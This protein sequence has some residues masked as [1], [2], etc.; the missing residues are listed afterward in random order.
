MMNNTNSACSDDWKSRIHIGLYWTKTKPTQ[1][2]YY[3]CSIRPDKED[4][5]EIV[6]VENIIDEKGIQ[7]TI[8]IDEYSNCDINDYTD[9]N[10]WYGPI[11]PPMS[12]DPA[13]ILKALPGAYLPGMQRGLAYP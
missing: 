10:W 8:G 13:Y 1:P 2:G 12:N 5:C 7:K 9:N 11:K 6:K 4:E 3:W